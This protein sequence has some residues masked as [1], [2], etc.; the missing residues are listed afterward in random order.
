MNR[1]DEMCL[2][3]QESCRD[4]DKT[5]LE[6]TSLKRE[7]ERL[8]QQREQEIAE[9]RDDIARKDNKI[10]TLTSSLE[11]SNALRRVCDL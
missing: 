4:R 11:K 2:W 5:L 3:M 1:D 6:V 7:I 10:V 8:I 9:K